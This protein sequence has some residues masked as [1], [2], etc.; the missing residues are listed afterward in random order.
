MSE[1]EFLARLVDETGCRLLLD[2][3]NVYVS[4]VNH[5]FDPL[6]FIRNIP[7]AAVVQFHLAGHTRTATHLIDTHDGPVIDPVWELYREAQRLTGGAATLLEW[8]G[9]HSGVPRRSRRSAQGSRSSGIGT[10]DG[11]LCRLVE[12]RG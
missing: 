8:D 3:N 5:D 11:S 1:W 4:S 2:V 9:A 6:E 10:A 7:H 12:Q